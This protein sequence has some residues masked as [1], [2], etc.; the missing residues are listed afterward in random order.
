MLF[1][2]NVSLVGRIS[3]RVLK[4]GSTRVSKGVSDGFG[5]GFLRGF[6]KRNYRDS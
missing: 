5:R 3:D 6:R 2:L 1:Y 4:G